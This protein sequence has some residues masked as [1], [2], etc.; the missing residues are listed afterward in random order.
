VASRP[1][2]ALRRASHLPPTPPLCLV[3]F[4]IAHPAACPCSSV[5]FHLS[6]F[7]CFLLQLSGDHRLLAADTPADFRQVLR[8]L[9]DTPLAPPHWRQHR[10]ALLA[11]GAAFEPGSAG[12]G[13][14][15]SGGGGAVGT[16]LLRGYVRGLGLS[17][18]QAVHIPGAGDFQLAAIQGPPEP[19][20]ANEP[21]PAAQQ[22]GKG[23][24]G[25]VAMDTSG[26]GG[27]GSDLPVLAVPDPAQ[28]EPLTRENNV[29]P[30]AGEQTWPTEE[31]R[32]CG[33][34]WA[35]GCAASQA[36]GW[37]VMGCG[38]CG[39]VQQRRGS[40]GAVIPTRALKPHRRPPP[41]PAPPPPQELMEAEAAPRRKRRL[42]RGTSDY[43]AAWILDDRWG[44]GWWAAPCAGLAC[45][46]RPLICVV[47]S[48]V[49]PLLRPLDIPP[50]RAPAPPPSPP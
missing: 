21:S 50:N 7:R 38:V 22:P 48:H 13:S 47:P 35:A 18:N 9:S 27:G 25:A 15:G 30:L 32:R 2:H 41:L 12:D 5:C 34:C 31:V 33:G 42:P 28:Q 6:V 29:D 36:G 45:V 44:C 14:D 46:C 1:A 17:A 49:R 20:A 4:V 3:P 10:P 39:G 16:L 43:Q 11:E 23:G 24:S 40:C 8:A 26:G 37:W 19:P